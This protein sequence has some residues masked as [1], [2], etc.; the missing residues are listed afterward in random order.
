M[1]FGNMMSNEPVD[2]EQQG[3]QHQ[4]SP[5]PRLP[6]TPLP[7]GKRMTST[8]SR[9]NW[10]HQ[11]RSTWPST[12]L[13]EMAS[14]LSAHHCVPCNSTQG[15]VSSK[16]GY[17]RDGSEVCTQLMIL[18]ERLADVIYDTWIMRQQQN[19][20]N[21]VG[22]V[23]RKLMPCG[24]SLQHTPASRVVSKAILAGA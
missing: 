20:M 10:Q 19:L 23:A 6:P 2:R 5:Q 16:A 8:N 9:P 13:T 24:R 14:W 21:Y 3:W 17:Q 15:S 4:R 12:Q 22:P 18:R 1:N 7:A 11:S